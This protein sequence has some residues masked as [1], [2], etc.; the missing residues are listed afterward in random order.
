MAVVKY[1]ESFIWTGTGNPPSTSRV[2]I[3]DN[4]IIYIWNGT[5][6]VP[7]SNHGIGSIGPQGPQGPPGPQGPAGE[8]GVGLNIDGVVLTYQELIDSLQDNAVG[9]VW[10]VQENNHVYIWSGYEWVDMGVW[11]ALTGAQGP[12]GPQGPQGPASVWVEY[13]V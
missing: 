5:A 7:A 4:G 10:Y 11:S 2:W 9:E 3:K 12:A 6:W 8:R 1:D 13:L